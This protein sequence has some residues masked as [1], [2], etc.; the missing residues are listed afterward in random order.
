MCPR[1]P[2]AF[3][4]GFSFLLSYSYSLYYGKNGGKVVVNDVSQQ[5]A[6]KVVDE[7]KAGEWPASALDRVLTVIQPVDRLSQL[8]AP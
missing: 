5:N 2:L 4:F 8:W 7:V 1:C 6:Q 3:L